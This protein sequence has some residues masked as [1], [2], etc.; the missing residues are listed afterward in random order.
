MYYK[1]EQTIN[2]LS[3]IYIFSSY[4]LQKSFNILFQLNIEA[5]YYN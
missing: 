5:S 3:V 2:S 1:K 4:L